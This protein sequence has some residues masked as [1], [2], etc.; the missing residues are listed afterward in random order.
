MDLGGS[1]VDL[2]WVLVDLGASWWILVH[3]GWTL[4]GWVLA[5]LGELDLDWILDGFWVDSSGSW[6]ISTGSLWILVDLG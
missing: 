4:V 3:L 2:R 1:L 6:W 5:D